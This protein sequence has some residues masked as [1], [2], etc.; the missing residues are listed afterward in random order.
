MKK[1]IRNEQ[2]YTEKKETTEK[3]KE[4]WIQGEVAK[5]AQ[6]KVYSSLDDDDECSTGKKGNER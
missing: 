5:N 1:R 3:W 6:G 4:L 2:N